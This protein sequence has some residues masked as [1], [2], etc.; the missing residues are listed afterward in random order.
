LTSIVFAGFFLSYGK[1]FLIQVFLF[2]F[3]VHAS[4][5]LSPKLHL[6]REVLDIN[7]SLGLAGIAVLA[8]KRT[9]RQWAL[10]LS[11]L[12][13]TFL[14]LVVFN[15]TFWPHNGLELLP[16]LCLLGG[17]FIAEIIR[18]IGER[19]PAPAGLVGAGVFVLLWLLIFPVKI[20]DWGFG[21]QK[22]SDIAEL[23]RAVQA[24][25]NPAEFVFVPSIIA[26]EANRRE[27]IP[28]EEIAGTM[29]D[30]EQRVQQKGWIGTLRDSGVN[31]ENFRYNVEHSR[32][33]YLPQLVS[34]IRNGLVPVVINPP[35]QG[36]GPFI[37]VKIK[38]EFLKEIGYVPIYGRHNYILWFLPRNV[39]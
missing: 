8:V 22:R 13:F 20:A 3:V 34:A 35:G 28:F 16:W 21:Y 10:C 4:G 12:L 17:C 32:E 33:F 11:E 7:L 5:T 19:K 1:N 29:I 30:L 9:F 27:V 31:K 26:F 24:H 25:T 18:S 23:S 38:E 14:F 37:P 6:F 39:R 36:I 15:A 2:Q